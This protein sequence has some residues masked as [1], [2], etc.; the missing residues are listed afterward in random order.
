MLNTSRQYSQTHTQHRGLCANISVP[1]VV[2]CGK[3]LNL[4]TMR[5]AVADRN[6]RIFAPV[7]LVWRRERQV[8]EL[9]HSNVQW[10]TRPAQMYAFTSD[11]S[12]SINR[13]PDTDGI[14]ATRWPIIDAFCKTCPHNCLELDSRAL[15]LSSSMGLR[16]LNFYVFIRERTAA[17]ARL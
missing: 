7:E 12:A 9:T 4:N 8:V 2:P 3:L 1:Q 15:V 16:N 17:N 11:A 13:E 6:H 10:T 14:A 5:A